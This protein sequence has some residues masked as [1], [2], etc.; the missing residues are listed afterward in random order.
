MTGQGGTS[1]QLLELPLVCGN[2]V[3]LVILQWPA[4]RA[5]GL[6]IDSLA[7]LDGWPRCA[8][9]SKRRQFCQLQR[10]D[11]PLSVH[12]GSDVMGDTSQAT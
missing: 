2:F 9:K 12:L 3:G 5:S 6:H 7:C 4:A 1:I 10:V 8:V 11:H